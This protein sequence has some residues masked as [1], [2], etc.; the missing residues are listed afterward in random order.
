MAHLRVSIL[1]LSILLLFLPTGAVGQEKER[2]KQ[3][4]LKQRLAF[5]K[6]NRFDKE[7]RYHGRW[8]VYLGDDKKL[9]RNGRFRHGAEVGKWKYYYP[10]G[11]LYMLEK[12]NRRD[13]SI[14]VSKYYENG[15]LARTGTARIIRSTFKDHYYWFG[16]WQVYDEQGAFSH[17]ET[18]KEGNLV[19]STKK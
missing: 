14:Q 15:S 8:K 11:T 13:N 4:A 3:G 6:N 16:E 12:Y 9:I 17:T 7:G 5:W 10:S 1:C 19:S 2:P 18:Y